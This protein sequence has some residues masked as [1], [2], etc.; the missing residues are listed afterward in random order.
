VGDYTAETLLIQSGK[1]IAADD[2]VQISIKKVG[3]EAFI[4]T[5]ADKYS[6]FY[7]LIAV[8]ISVLFGLAA[9]YIFQRL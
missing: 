4:T 6:L 8:L 9:G 5:L 2:N 1:V 3:F 7:G